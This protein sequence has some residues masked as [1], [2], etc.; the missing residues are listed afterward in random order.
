MII[1]G[2]TFGDDLER[3]GKKVVDAALN[4]GAPPA[5][6]DWLMKSNTYPISATDKQLSWNT[7]MKCR[8]DDQRDLY[9]LNAAL[10]LLNCKNIETEDNQPPSKLNRKRAKNGKQELFTYKT[11]VLKLPSYRQKPLGN[12]DGSDSKVRVHLCRGHFKIFTEAAP[13]FGKHTGLCWCPPHV[14]GDKTKGLVVKD[15][16][17]KTE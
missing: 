1:V 2:Q 5:F 11:L 4:C 15:Y 6:I 9:V 17:V 10:L 16:S 12:A 14:R 7:V 8:A 13:L 3:T